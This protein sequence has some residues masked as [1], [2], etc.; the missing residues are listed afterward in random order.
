MRYLIILPLFII[1][2]F[3]VS[4]SSGE[5]SRL[6]SENAQLRNALQE[7]QPEITAMHTMNAWLDSIDVNRHSFRDHRNTTL[8]S[9]T[10]SSRLRGVNRYVITSQERL[11]RAEEAL[12]QSEQ[13]VSGCQMMIDALRSEVGIRNEE[14]K[15]LKESLSIYQRS[16]ISLTHN[17]A[18]RQ[19]SLAGLREDLLLLQAKVDGLVTHLRLKEGDAMYAKARAVQ[20]AVQRSKATSSQKREAYREALEVYKKAFSLGNQE[21]AESIQELEWMLLT[22]PEL[23]PVKRSIL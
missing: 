20:E 22:D 16:H 17:T 4:C 21:A 1:G 8:A 11:E 12:R 10:V 6:R 9:H 5:L 3:L 13:T 18:A 23:H 15:D 19:D 2:L 14:I 7:Y